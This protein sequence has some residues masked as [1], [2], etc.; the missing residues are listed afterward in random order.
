M[1]CQCLTTNQLIKTKLNTDNYDLLVPQQNKT[2]NNQQIKSNDFN[3]SELNKNSRN[4]DNTFQNNPS[5]ISIVPLTAN[6]IN[7]EANILS[8]INPHSNNH[9]VTHSVNH[10]INHSINY[11]NQ[12]NC[13]KIN[14]PVNNN[15]NN[16][17]NNVSN[18]NRN[19]NNNI[20]NENNRR[21]NFFNELSNFENNL[22]IGRGLYLQSKNNIFFD[23]QIIEN[24]YVGKGVKRMNGYISPVSLKELKKIRDNFWTSR[25][26]GNPEIWEILRYL[27][28]DK[29]QTSE[30]IYAFMSSVGLVTLKGCINATFDDKGMLYEIPNYCINDPLKYKEVAVKEKPNK[31]NIE[32]IIKNFGKIVK[33]KTNNYIHIKEL[34]KMIIK[35]EEFSDVKGLSV[36]NV[37][38][39]FGGKELVNDKHVWFYDIFNKYIIQMMIRN[40]E[41]CEKAKNSKKRKN[42]H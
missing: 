20:N 22:D 21:R 13:I 41:G 25:V 37:R 24:E 19:I 17:S 12:N 30:E 5:S 3:L 14:E 34:K 4:I 39:F 38:L 27:C 16:N 6:N 33:I 7:P 32:I 10:S 40:T 23:Y 42:E 35:R 31:E 15:I 8:S 29:T 28:E 18:S 36:N 1:G 9:S 26:E 2:N 11:N